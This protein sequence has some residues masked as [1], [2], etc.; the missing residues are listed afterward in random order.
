[1]IAFPIMLGKDASESETDKVGERTQSLT[2]SRNLLVSASDAC[3]RLFSSLKEIAEL[4][5][6]TDR[7]YNMFHVFE[8]V[9]ANNFVRTIE[10]SSIEE[11]IAHAVACPGS[12]KHG[13]VVKLSSLPRISPVYSTGCVDLKNVP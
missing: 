1:M 13:E 2:T 3:E 8:D 7:V 9:H 4:M 11:E 6:H 10:G 5:G 12:L